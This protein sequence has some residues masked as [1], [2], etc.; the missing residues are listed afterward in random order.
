[1]WAPTRS[2][3]N[4]QEK[5]SQPRKMTL[6]HV[7]NRGIEAGSLQLRSSMATPAGREECVC[8]YNCYCHQSIFLWKCMAMMKWELVCKQEECMAVEKSTARNF[9][10]VL[11]W[12]SRP[13]SHTCKQKDWQFEIL[14]VNY[15]FL[16]L[17]LCESRNALQYVCVVDKKHTLMD[18][19]VWWVTKF[20]HEKVVL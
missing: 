16:E 17:I 2:S 18:N 1:M 7:Y 12:R 14:F 3:N 8:V 20:G 5:L 4:L 19:A 6:F 11:A 10:S 15:Y 13:E 9:V